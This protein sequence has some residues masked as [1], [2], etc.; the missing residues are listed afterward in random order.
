MKLFYTQ[1]KRLVTLFTIFFILLAVIFTLIILFNPTVENKQK[2]FST[3]SIKE[4]PDD[5]FKGI[6]KPDILDSYSL[7]PS[8]GELTKVHVSNGQQ[9]NQGDNLLTYTQKIDNSDIDIDNLKFS[10]KS[11][12]QNL[13]NANQDLL[14]AQ[15]KDSEL[16]SEFYKADE[17]KKIEIINKIETNNESWKVASRAVQAAQLALD[18]ANTN[19]ENGEKKIEQTSKINVVKAKSK[20][21]AM[22]SS[23]DSDTTSIVKILDIN[24]KVTAQVSEFDFKYIKVG[25]KVSVEP[26]NSEEK[27][28]GTIINIS[29]T[30]LIK[31]NDT[32]TT[33]YEFIVDLDKNLQNGFNVHVRLK[34]DGYIIPKSAIHSNQVKLKKG[35]VF[36]T[37]TV[38][39]EEVNGK[40]LVREG[41]NKGDK[42]AKNFEE[43]KCIH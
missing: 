28:I 6:V 25:T 32:S 15:T 35:S 41:L 2:E 18:E 22:V 43:I 34:K 5:I 9:V 39:S 12:E 11:A 3:I 31:T 8:L 16:R 1:H 26:I 10:A 13:A 42:I 33:Y 40:I 21:V 30:P 23:S 27:S 7:D 24:N 38:K 37:T 14:E 4:Q 17:E 36:V 19:I 20:G 29:P